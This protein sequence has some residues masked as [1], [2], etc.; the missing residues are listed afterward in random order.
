MRRLD[1][2]LVAVL[3]L[4][5]L[6]ACQKEEPTIPALSA[7]C[8]AQ[9]A[10]GAPPLLVRFLLSVAGAE[11][12]YA[13]EISY[14][15]GASGSDP[16][17]P[18]TYATAGA[19]TASFVVTTAT[20]SARCAAAVTVSGP[21]PSPS[22]VGN[23]PPHPVFKTT[24]AARNDTVSGTAPFSM[25]LNLCLTSDPENDWLFFS[26]DYEGDGV[27][28]SRG[29]FGGN[30]R[31]DHVYAAGTY[32]PTLCVHDIDHDRRPLHED[33]CHTFTVIVSP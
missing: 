15:D 26:M 33:Q 19:Y 18:H 23:Q 12:D 4:L 9:P 14:G 10:L 27:W 11:G 6:S 2:A 1:V 13:V 30:C 31:R 24:P 3:G 7:T 17:A 25:N 22:P 32:K 28:D 16:D 8:S 29:P 20:Q 21:T 5:A